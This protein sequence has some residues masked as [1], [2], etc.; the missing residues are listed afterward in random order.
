MVRGWRMRV[1]LDPHTDCLSS[2]SSGSD[3]L[4]EVIA[5]AGEV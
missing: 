4:R 3:G 5:K 1:I 2:Q